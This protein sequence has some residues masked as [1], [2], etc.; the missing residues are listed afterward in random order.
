VTRIEVDHD[1]CAGTGGCE[2]AAP[3]VFESRDDGVLVV[4][5]PEPRD[6]ELE[7]VRAA[8]GTCPTRALRLVEEAG[9]E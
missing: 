6:D 2:A 8:V 5:R 4:L 1:R 7:L 3:E 9:V